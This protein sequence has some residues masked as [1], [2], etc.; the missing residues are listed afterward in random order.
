M[1]NLLIITGA[2]ASYDVINEEIIS[3]EA[4]G[5]SSYRPPLTKNIF[6]PPLPDA[7]EVGSPDE[8]SGY[9]LTCL[10]EHPLAYQAG[11]EFHNLFGK[12]N[13]EAN[14]EKF[15]S[16][17]KSSNKFIIKSQFWA[18][19]LYLYDLFFKISTG[20]LPTSYG[21][22]SNY[23]SLIDKISQSNYNQIIWLNLNYDLLADYAIK[24]STNN[25]LKDLND[26][27]ELQTQDGLKIKYT[28]P[29]GSVD[30]FKKISDPDIRWEDIKLGRLPTGFESRLSKEIYKEGSFPETQAFTTSKGEMTFSFPEGWYPAITAPIGEYDFVYQRHVKDIVPDLKKTD[31]ILCIGFGALDKDILELIKKEMPEIKK[32]QIVNGPRAEGEHAHQRIINHCYNVT[33]NH[34]EA[35]FEGGFTQFVKKGLED[36][37]RQ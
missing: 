4:S 35:V 29:H 36:W 22:P 19:P 15:L 23:K 20:Y 5:T 30:W 10:R 12:N 24:I 25:E 18:I 17:L 21:L 11:Y 34:I 2:G 7:R 3:S 33:L 8:E 37:L 31:A 27:M 6:Y 16:E 13:A 14:L 9:I 32:L 26:Y 1:N 28:K